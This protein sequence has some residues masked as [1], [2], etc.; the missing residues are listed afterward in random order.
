MSDREL[1]MMPWFPKDFAAAT[2]AWSFAEASL[3][4]CLLD[5]QWLTGPLPT[6]PVRLARI[7]KCDQPTFDEAWPAV[8]TKFSDVSGCLVNERLEEHRAEAMRRKEINASNGARGGK[9]SG[10]A[11]LKRGLSEASSP[12]QAMGVAKSNPPS[13]SPSP[14][15][16]LKEEDGPS[17]PLFGDAEP[18][19]E[20]PELLFLYS[21]FL[22]IA[23]GN[24]NRPRLA[25]LIRD[26]RGQEDTVASA[27]RAVLEQ[28]EKARARGDTLHDP[29]AYLA[30]RVAQH[31]RSRPVV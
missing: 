13:P 2:A 3:Y 4:R 29:F 23:G 14:S 9:A 22:P 1:P 31:H 25:K 20:N 28:Y 16:S 24:K 6:D 5:A 30:S 19:D 21:T 7:A 17:A 8:R 15:P 27:A 26:T 11:R 10:Q 18:P 12:A